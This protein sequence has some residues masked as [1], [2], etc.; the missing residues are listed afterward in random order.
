MVKTVEEV[1]PQ[2]KFDLNEELGPQ[3]EAALEV[4]FP[5]PPDLGGQGAECDKILKLGLREAIAAYV[6]AAWERASQRSELEENEALDRVG[7]KIEALYDALLDLLEYPGLEARLER[8]IRSFPHH[9]EAVSGVGFPQLIGSERNI[10]QGF[11]EMLVDLQACAEAEINRKP[12]PII[13]EALE[14][15]EEPLRLDTD[16]ELEEQM[17][18]WRKRSKNRKFEKDHALLEFLRTFKPY[19]EQATPHPFTEGMHYRE[20][21][22]TLSTLVGFLER[23]MELVDGGVTNANLVTSIRKLRERLAEDDPS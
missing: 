2:L 6:D 13:I 4:L 3:V 11:R 8:Q 15:G 7:Q 19:W 20:I 9:Y 1:Y 12:K 23:T 16:E 10:F 17:R 14:E 22:G 18:V 5:E 21:G